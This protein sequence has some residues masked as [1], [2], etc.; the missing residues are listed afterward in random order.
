MLPVFA[1]LAISCQ[2]ED[3]GFTRA[4]VRQ[5]VISREYAEEFLAA[6][7]S[8]DSAHTWMCEPDTVYYGM[9]GAPTRAS[10]EVTILRDTDQPFLIPAA[11]VA[12][13]LDYMREGE[14]NRGKCAQ[15][16]EY[17]AVGETTYDIYPVFWGRKFSDTN[18]IGVYYI[19]TEGNR[20]DLESFWSD[21][22]RS[23]ITVFKDGE[24]QSITQTEYPINEDPN[25][26]WGQSQALTHKCSTCNGRGQ[27]N[28]R[29]CPNCTDGQSPIDHFELPHF[30]LTVPSGVKWGIY[31]KTL[32]TQ[33]SHDWITW[34]SNASYNDDQV[35]AAA[36][37]TF[38]NVTYCSFEDAPHNLH[39][40][41]GTGN[42]SECHYG[43]YDQD[44]NDIV[45]VITPRP[46]ESTYR[47]IRYRVMC[48]DLGG[49]FDW[50]FNDVVYDV[51][52]EGS[53][54]AGEMATLSIIV[55]AV[56]G[57]LPIT[58]S[59]YKD[60]VSDAMNSGELHEAMS[61]QTPDADGLYTPINVGGDGHFL[62]QAPYLVHRIELDKE[63]Y[64]DIDELDIREYVRYITIQVGRESEAIATVRFP[65]P[66]G[67]RVPQCF[68]TSTGT[69]W[70]DELQNIADKYHQFPEWVAD[71]TRATAWWLQSF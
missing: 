50:D 41:G 14:D 52:Y 64:L 45:L 53:K 57:T 63:E 60:D 49:T 15:N 47:A 12:S 58:I 29:D 26:R 35:P 28:G 4:D 33:N 11:D 36:T 69:E 27:K 39:N 34:Y 70:A 16:F 55:Q 51:V 68:M 10:G 18:Y 22:D 54:H 38:N 19:D 23:I 1:C 59:Y 30:R 48:E 17:L 67:D 46:I 7:P 37:F 20:Q 21:I 62:M 9:S 8:V 5:S 65:E 66:N 40:G 56:G 42:C 3:F 13:A 2:D 24:R 6:F 31:L 25:Q 44:F 61:G 71:H 32:R 43:H